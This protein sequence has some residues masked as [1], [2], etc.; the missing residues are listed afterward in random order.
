MSAFLLCRRGATGQ[1]HV[2]VPAGARLSTACGK[3][4]DP[5]PL[6]V[7]RS[8]RLIRALWTDDEARRCLR[9]SRAVSAV[10]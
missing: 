5:A 7:W 4:L 10:R 6:T 1:L 8:R 2:A 3:R 9:C